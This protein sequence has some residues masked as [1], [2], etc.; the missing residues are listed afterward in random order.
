[1]SVA[2]TSRLQAL[3]RYNRSTAQGR[4]MGLLLS[5]KL[6]NASI[7]VIEAPTKRSAKV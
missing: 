6:D 1:L 4:D 2:L 7:S 5:I 3:D